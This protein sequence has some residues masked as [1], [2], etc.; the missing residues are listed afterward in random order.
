MKGKGQG[1]GRRGGKMVGK[2]EKKYPFLG[3]SSRFI[4]GEQWRGDTFQV[5]E[6]G[7]RDRK[8]LLRS[9]ELRA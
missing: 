6:M 9:L 3:S 5:E 2:M 7:H 8:A 4:R 1:K